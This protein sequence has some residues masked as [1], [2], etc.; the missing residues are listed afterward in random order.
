LDFWCIFWFG[1]ADLRI[2]RGVRVDTFS[3]ML[4]QDI[5]FFDGH[6]SGELSSRLTSDCGQMS[7]DLVSYHSQLRLFVERVEVK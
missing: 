1:Y 4:K 5:A 2:V 6:T 3:S 7:G